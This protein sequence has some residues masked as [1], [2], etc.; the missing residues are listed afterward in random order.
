MYTKTFKPVKEKN[1]II[2]NFLFHMFFS[3]E[4]C[5]CAFGPVCGVNH[6]RHPPL[7]FGHSSH[8]CHMLLAFVH[9]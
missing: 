2:Q 1:I 6:C 9:A 5:L 8:S 3:C 4:V 7:C